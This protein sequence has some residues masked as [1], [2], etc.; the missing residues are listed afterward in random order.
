MA[1]PRQRK[2]A[3]RG[4]V[5]RDIVQ[6]IPHKQGIN[7]SPDQEN[8]LSF[9]N[10]AESPVLVIHALAGTGKSTVPGFILDAYMQEMP[11]KEAV[12]TLWL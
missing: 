5:R 2:H 10:T 3:F 1:A 12:A 4:R 7:L 6:G 9:V 8:V 11:D